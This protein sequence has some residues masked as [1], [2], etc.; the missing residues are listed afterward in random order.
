MSP[1]RFWLILI[2]MFCV[3]SCTYTITMVHSQG[4]AKDVVD[5]TSSPTA[6]TEASIPLDLK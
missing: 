5:T 2:A 3:T 1:K 6:D 4:T